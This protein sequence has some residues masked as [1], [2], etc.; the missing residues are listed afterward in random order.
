MLVRSSFG[1][2][3]AN[4]AAMARA[5]VACGWFGIQTWIGGARA[6][7]ADD[8]ADARAGPTSSGHKAIAFGVFWLVQVAI[9]LRG[10]EGIKFLE[11][12]A[13]P[14]LLG[15][16]RRAADLGA[17]RGRRIGNVF[18]RLV[19]AGRRRPELL[20]AV[21]PGPRGE[22]RLLDHALD[23]HPRLHA[24]RHATSARRSSARASRMPLTM[25]GFSFIG[26]AVTR[27]RSSIYGEAIWDPVDARRAAARRPAGPARARDGHRRHRAALDE[28]GGQRR[29]AVE[30]LLEPLAAPDLVPRPAA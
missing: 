27:P 1:I 5:L 18:S 3:G 20:G 10:I 25:T 24:L 2:R 28:H 7:H 17:S 6:R 4:V 30:R 11:S 19:E 29:L 8:D 13:A 21:R 12:W 16:E 23:E 22:R 14:L 26:I 15:G 9:I